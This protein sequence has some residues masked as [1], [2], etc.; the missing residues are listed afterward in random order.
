MFA[1]LTVSE[2]G[3]AVFRVV[4]ENWNQDGDQVGWYPSFPT[5]LHAFS[6]QSAALAFDDDL[7]APARLTAR[8]TSTRAI[9]SIPVAR[10]VASTTAAQRY[11]WTPSLWDFGWT[12]GESLTSPPSRGTRDDRGWWL[13]SSTGTGRAAKHNGGLMLDSQ[14]DNKDGVGRS[15]GTTRATLQDQPMRYGRWEVRLRAKSTDT[16]RSDFH[17]L[18][19]LVPADPAADGCTDPRITIADVTAHGSGL[20]IGVRNGGTIW[21]RTEPGIKVNGTSHALAVE[22][23][24][25]HITWFVEGRPIGT[26][27]KSA[28]IPDVPMTLRVSLV[29]DGEQAMNRTQSI[30]DWMRGYSLS[31]GEKVSSGPRLTGRSA[32]C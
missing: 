32:S 25:K 23:T 19:E 10:D 8:A 22:V 21:S 14:R 31:D 26:V 4:Q 11:R 6:D 18:I 2:P 30:F 15:T 24:S 3:E 28:A 5:Y 17:T 27:R 7:V 12:Y 20:G 1:G 29:G 9:G 16:S 13:D